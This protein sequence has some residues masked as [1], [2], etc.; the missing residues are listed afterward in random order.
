MANIE[1]TA[2]GYILSEDERDMISKF[3]RARSFKKDLMDEMEEDFEFTAGEQWDDNDVEELKKVGV[4]A[5]TI[6]KIQPNIFLLSGIQRQNR[7]DFRAYPEGQEDSLKADIATR[8]LKNAMKRSNGEYKLSEVFEDGIIG[9]EG[10]IQFTIDYTH[11]L[12]NGELRLKKVSPFKVYVDPDS[13]EYDHSDAEYVF[14]LTQDLSCDQVVKLFP[15]KEKKI[16][17]LEVTKISVDNLPGPNPQSDGDYRENP[18]YNNTPEE[19]DQITETTYDL[20]EMEYKKYVTKYLVIDLSLGTYKMID[21]KQEAEEYAADVEMYHG[22]PKVK[23]VKRSIPETWVKVMIGNTI[24]EEHISTLYPR[25]KAFSIIPFYAHRMTTDIKDKSAMLQGIV[26]S[27]KCLQLEVNKRRTQALRHL[28]TSTNSGWKIHKSAKVDEGKLHKYGSSPAFVLKWEGN[29]EPQQ[30]FPQPMNQG[31]EYMSK[32]SSED[33]K[34]VSGINADLLAMEDKSASGRAIYLRQ[35]QGIVMVQRILDNFQH[36]KRL[37]GRLILSQL[38]ELYSVETASRVLGEA[39]IKDNFSVPVHEIA[40]QVQQKVAQ[41]PNY[42]PTQE[43]ARAVMQVQEWQAQGQQGPVLDQQGQLVMG[44]D[45]DAAG[46]VINQILL[47]DE[48]AKYDV[49]VGESQSTETVKLANYTM[50]M[51]LMEKGIPIPPEILIEESLLS[52]DSK[53]QIREAIE[54]ARQAQGVQ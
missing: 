21:S 5:L 4:K 13:I 38:G 28:N 1:E 41:N 40:G 53:N 15:D 24:I 26:R 8:L 32:Q 51:D 23:V 30:I 18:S 42:Q 7:T 48:I 50:L 39:F 11:D 47:D 14:K 45:Q 46:A 19:F 43:E 6:N 25:W 9:G 27:M 33:M 20:L 3:K 44:V 35:Q 17:G 52:P 10:D 29:V 2:E 36:T 54:N 34:A 22:E 16:K 31:L 37:L 49:S 12:I